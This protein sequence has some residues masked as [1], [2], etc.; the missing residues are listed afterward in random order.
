MGKVY[1]VAE[2]GV[3]HWGDM[4][5][6]K[7]LIRQAKECDSDYVKFQLYDVDK[8]FPD[9]KIMARGENWY[10][11][12]KPTQLTKE[13][14]KML[15]NYGEEIGIEV[16]FSVFDVERVGWC[17]EIGVKRYKTGFI[18][19][20]DQSL[21]DAINKTNKPLYYSCDCDACF[22]WDNMTLFWKPLYCIPKYPAI[23]NDCNFE[24]EDFDEMWHGFS[25]H[26]VG[27]EASMIAMSRGARIIEKHFCLTRER[28]GV[29]I[30]LSITPDE[31]KQLVSFA[32]KVE[33]A[34]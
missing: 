21:I 25:D 20:Y 6:A 28:D 26:T 34:L 11:M 19:R 4:E 13:Q 33:Q 22:Y 23:L 1:I 15:F 2:C 32:R 17:E 10:E 5:I 7:E 27:L 16:F 30:P 8:V 9:K 14:A 3:N 29:D 12:V 18:S 24:S 31:L